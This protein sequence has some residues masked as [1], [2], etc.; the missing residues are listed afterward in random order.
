MRS[1]IGV[2]AFFFSKL[3][4]SETKFGQPYEPTGTELV[5]PAELSPAE[6]RPSAASLY[7]DGIP[8]IF[9]AYTINGYTYYKLRD[10][11]NV[12]GFRVTWDQA[13]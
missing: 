6:A 12:I 5:V 3:T 9:T 4:F 10:I 13:T 11:G 8:E 1:R 7:V 2:F